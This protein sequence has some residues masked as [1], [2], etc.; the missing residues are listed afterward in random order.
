MKNKEI[1]AAGL[2]ALALLAGCSKEKESTSTTTSTKSVT[3]P[4]SPEEPTTTKESTLPPQPIQ[5]A[6]N[7]RF[8]GS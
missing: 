6:N 5:K 2:V 4:A 7:I 3:T 8:A 1:I